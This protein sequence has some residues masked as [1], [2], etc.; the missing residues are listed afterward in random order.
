MILSVAVVSLIAAIV[1]RKTYL[2]ARCNR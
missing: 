1:I 2:A